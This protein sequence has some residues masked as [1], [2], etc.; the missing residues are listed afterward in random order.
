LSRG[1]FQ[2]EK[3]DLF[4]FLILPLL[5]EGFRIISGDYAVAIVGIDFDL[6]IYQFKTGI[7]RSL[8]PGE[9][10]F[11]TEKFGFQK[12]FPQSAFFS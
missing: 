1:N 5:Q 7:I 11:L 8:H 10:G 4:R 9:V 12:K 3:N 2:I 6:I